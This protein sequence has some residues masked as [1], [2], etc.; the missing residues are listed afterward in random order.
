MLHCNDRLSRDSLQLA[1]T[2]SAGSCF[3]P[4]SEIAVVSCQLLLTLFERRSSE[5]H[6]AQFAF[7]AGE[8]RLADIL[9]SKDMC[10]RQIDGCTRFRND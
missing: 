4:D 2:C 7:T 1:P 6:Q 9:H 8:T 5:S 3:V 10:M